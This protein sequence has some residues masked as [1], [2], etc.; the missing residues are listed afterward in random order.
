MT[1]LANRQRGRI[2]GELCLMIGLGALMVVCTLVA[3]ASLCV[4]LD[5]E[6]CQ[7]PTASPAARASS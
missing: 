6:D 2:D 4:A 7:R 1:K 3:I 5:L